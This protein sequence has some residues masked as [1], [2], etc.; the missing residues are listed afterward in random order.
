MVTDR[1]EV[2]SVLLCFVKVNF[3]LVVLLFSDSAYGGTVDYTYDGLGVT[4]TY[5]IEL[6]PSESADNGDESG[7][8]LPAC[9]II[10]SGREIMAA[11]KAITPV[12]AKSERKVKRKRKLTS[13]HST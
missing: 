5:T 8:I 3:D 13:Q 6:R 2:H 4:H 11:F 7:F 12:M 9:Q 10:D 1:T